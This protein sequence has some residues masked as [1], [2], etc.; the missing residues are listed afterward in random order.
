M[1]SSHISCYAAELSRAFMEGTSLK[2]GFCMV[3]AVDDDSKFMAL[4]ESMANAL[5]IRLHRV[6]KRN[7]KA[8]GVERYH[9]FLNHN[10]TILSA[11]RQT[12]KCFVEVALVSAYAW[13]AMPIDGTD[14][15]RSIPAI[16]R[17]FRFHIDVTLAELPTPTTNTAKST[18]AYIR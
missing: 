13:N 7:H 11:A 14:I 5:N 10:A 2:L 16:G 17:P 18:V 15:I 3:V 6:A 12:H 1:L 8:I 9:K 4:F